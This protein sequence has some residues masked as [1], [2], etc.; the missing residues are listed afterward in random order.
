MLFKS[1]P[2]AVSKNQSMIMTSL[3]VAGLI[4]SV[5]LAVKATT[6]AIPRIEDAEFDKKGESLT[7]V[8]IVKE[9]WMDYIP[10]AVTTS[11]SIGCII[12][13][14]KVNMR[15]QAAL[16]AA[17]LLTKDSYETFRESVAEKLTQRDIDDCDRIS[18]EKRA[19]N[20]PTGGRT[21]LIGSGNCMF[22]DL[23]SGRTF[24]STVD[25]VQRA[26][27][28]LNRI[29]FNEMWISLNDIYYELGLET[30]KLGWDLGVRAGTTI[31][32][33]QTAILL[34]DGTP[35]IAL[36]INVEPKEVLR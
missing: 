17:Y 8:E 1:F 2:L 19:N 14:H 11:L 33:R 9:C 7:P 5:V 34:D 30:T 12:G 35:A 25:K 23:V 3:G 15:K 26:E 13:A 28:E 20:L 24:T 18:A 21:V 36:D 29:L 4:S 6:K 31:D 22:K 32:F 10:V 16:S 27:N